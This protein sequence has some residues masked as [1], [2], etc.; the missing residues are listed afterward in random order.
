MLSIEDKR[1]IIIESLNNSFVDRYEFF[2]DTIDR[3]NKLFDDYKI[4]FKYD[5]NSFC[6]E[7]MDKCLDIIEKNP[8]IDLTDDKY[9]L[10]YGVIAA[11]MVSDKEKKYGISGKTEK[12]NI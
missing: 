5:Y 8:E 6:K 2:K 10:I 12:S 7:Y 3:I 1:K 4:D 11:S 9:F